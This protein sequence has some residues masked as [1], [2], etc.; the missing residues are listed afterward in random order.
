MSI[1][2]LLNK[3]NDLVLNPIIIL[4]FAVALLVFFWGVV[5]FINSETADSKRAE[6]QRKL[7]FGLLGMFIMIS[8]FG[9][10]RFIL[11]TFRITASGYPFN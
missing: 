5:Q 4:A 7:I 3:V 9:I 8:A 1:T 11:S 10:I 6:G 2:E